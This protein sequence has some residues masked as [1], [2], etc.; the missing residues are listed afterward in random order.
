M[1]QSKIVKELLNRRPGTLRFEAAQILDDVSQSFIEVLRRD[2]RVVI[3]GLGS[4]SL[5]E[6]A[7]RSGFNPA[8]GARLQIPAKTV[9]KFQ[10]SKSLRDGVNIDR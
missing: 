2:G 5:Q 3:P 10:P 1:N 6:R 9:V 7:G 4:L 8:T